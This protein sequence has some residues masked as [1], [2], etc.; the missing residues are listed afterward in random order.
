MS[1]APSTSDLTWEDFL[2]LPDEDRYRHTELVDGVLVHKHAARVDGELALAN[3]PTWLHQQ[4]VGAVYAFIWHWIRAGTGRGTVTLEPPVQIRTKRAYLPDVAWFRE[5]RSRPSAG[6]PYVTGA[7]DLA[8]EVLSPSTRNVDLLRKR[9]DY[10]RAGVRELWLIDPDESI[11]FVL[12][13]PADPPQPAE[14]VQV[15]ELDADGVLSSP[16]LP[17][18]EIPVRELLP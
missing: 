7:P 9:V 16:L 15:E 1:V 3:P 18:L 14:F 11:V 5:E 12:R 4:L 17:G 6:N 10:A 13:L 8:V 2:N